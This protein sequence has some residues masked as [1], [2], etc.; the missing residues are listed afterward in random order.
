MISRLSAS[1]AVFAVVA[2][3]GIALVAGAQQQ[4]AAPSRAAAAA[5]GA[6]GAMPGA[7]LRQVEVTVHRRAQTVLF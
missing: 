1:A 2:T 4:R 3:T 5:A 6:S 7:V